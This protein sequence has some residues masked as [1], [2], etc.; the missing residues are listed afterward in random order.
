VQLE[1]HMSVQQ[2]TDR[3]D[4]YMTISHCLINPSDGRGGTLPTGIEVLIVIGCPKGKRVGRHG[5]LAVERKTKIII[6]QKQ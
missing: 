1:S 4:Y 5:I 3:P 2:L 6:Q